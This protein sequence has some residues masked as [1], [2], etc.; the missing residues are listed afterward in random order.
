MSTPLFCPNKL[1]INHRGGPEGRRWFHRIGG[2]PTAAFGQVQRYICL[3]CKARFSDQTFALDYYV[4]RPVSYAR[5][6]DKI[7]AGSGLRG[8]GRSLQISHQ[9][10]ANRIGRLARQALALQ[11]QLTG[12]LQLGE[13]LVVDGFESFVTDQY[14]PNNIHLLVGALSQFLYSFDY[15]HL[16]RKGRMRPK[17]KGER[18]RREGQYLREPI[19]IT[20]SFV[21]IIDEVEQL[22]SRRKG[23]GALILD[24]DERKEYRR[25][26]ERSAVLHALKARGKFYHRR[27]NSK[28]PR[29]TSNRLFAVNYLDRQIRKDNANHVRETVQ[30][31][32]DVNNCM[33]R[34]AVYQLYHNYLKPY[35]VEGRE[36]RALRHGEVAGV[37]R[38]RIDREL[39]DIFRLRRFYSHVKLSFSQ[40]LLWARMIGNR[41]RLCGG[42]WPQYVWM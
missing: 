26:I 12:E 29:T 36:A 25:V 11:A 37:A 9:G 30:F 16:R 22:A 10:I 15:A 21:R 18:E 39:A 2:Y 13:H 1:C 5:L 19:S 33:E 34:M 23:E 17:Q 28:E 6:F 20:A 3:H 35:R 24:S 27:T 40:L 4:K 7:T 41:D 8:T 32:R 42:Y 31:S 14:M 38:E